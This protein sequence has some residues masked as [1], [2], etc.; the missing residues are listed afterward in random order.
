[1]EQDVYR[2]EDET[3]RRPRVSPRDQRR[4]RIAAFVLTVAAVV[5]GGLAGWIWIN[6]ADLPGLDR[7]RLALEQTATPISTL[8]AAALD[9]DTPAESTAEEST[10]EESAASDPVD[11]RAVAEV[12]AADAGTGQG[13]ESLVL[14]NPIEPERAATSAARIQE[15]LAARTPT[16]TPTPLPQLTGLDAV[17]ARG[18][19]ELWAED[20][21]L[22]VTRLSQGM[23]FAVEART[24]DGNW[25]LGTAPDGTRG[26]IAQTNVIAFDPQRLNTRSTTVVPTT[27]TPQVAQVL[28]PT[29]TPGSGEPV[30]SASGGSSTAP[31]GGSAPAA[32]Q[33]VLLDGPVARISLADARLNVRAGPGAQH[34]IVTKAHPDERF[35]V[36]GRTAQGDWVQLAISDVEGGFGWVTTEYVEIT[37]TLDE[38]PLSTAVSSAPPYVE[39]AEGE[40]VRQQ[41]QGA[42]QTS[43]QTTAQTPAQT[44]AQASEP[45]RP[46]LIITDLAP[47]REPY[48]QVSHAELEA[49]IQPAA[50]SVTG[51]SGKLAIQTTWGGDIYLYDFA[52]GALRHLTGGFDPALSPDGTQVAFTRD[53]GEHGL[54][55]INSDGS[56]ERRIFNGRELLRSPKWSPDGQWIVFE[57]GDEYTDCRDVGRR[58]PS[59]QQPRPGYPNGIF[60]QPMLARV[61][62]HG[63]NYR[64]LGVLQSARSPDWSHNGVVYASAAGIQLTKDKPD[65]VT[66]EVFFQIQ[67]QYELD[68]ALQPNGHSVVFQRREASHWEIYRVNLDGSGLTA[69][70]RPGFTLVRQLPANVA[71][72]WSSDGRHIV[73]LSNRQDNYEAG[74]WAIWVM[75]ADGS[76][77]RR[78]PIE[79]PITYTYVGEQMLSWSR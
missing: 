18:G 54:Y 42:I 69:L 11:D 2:I 40:R 56:N 26:W 7:D 55:L 30:T 45:A 38:V 32:S 41:R 53:G 62:V 78:L 76:N 61:D 73:F 79:L 1:M 43:S 20:N 74:E 64:D 67:K 29:P 47:G 19:A 8:P 50:Q 27:P 60:R 34:G 14:P 9:A 23:R 77:Q 4:N 66:T 63:G 37:G 44:P 24:T 17:I 51:L 3:Q 16:P 31:E 5:L 70:T 10:T 65:F 36:I 6:Q 22:Y 71:P 13:Q 75:D 72:A 49:Q 59:D 33:P 48:Q 25:L 12:P 39:G 68:P 21:Y 15:V 28:I 57:R 58:C 35:S 46:G 52:T